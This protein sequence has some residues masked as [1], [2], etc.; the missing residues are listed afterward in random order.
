[1]KFTN[2]YSPDHTTMTQ[3]MIRNVKGEREREKEEKQ[4][5]KNYH[6]RITKNLLKMCTYVRMY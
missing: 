4:E 3:T 2:F 1:M 5:K 6:T